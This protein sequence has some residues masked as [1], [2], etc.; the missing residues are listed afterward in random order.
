M[1]QIEEALERA[2]RNLGRVESMIETYRDYLQGQGSGRREVRKTDVLRAAVVFLHATL[3][4][5]LR[6]LAAWKLP[7]ANKEA[8]DGLPLANEDSF[9]R[10]TKFK[11]GDLVRHKGKEVDDLIQESVEKHLERSNYNNSNEVCSLLEKIGVDPS[12]IRDTLSDIDSMMERRHNIVH[13]ADEN[14]KKGKGHHFARP[15]NPR[16]VEEWKGVVRQF[17]SDVSDKL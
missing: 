14:P 13:R 2:K 17:I 11:L 6:T 1:S 15:I 16:R 8:L 4:D 10:A 7:E 3:E 9:N 5:F 12:I